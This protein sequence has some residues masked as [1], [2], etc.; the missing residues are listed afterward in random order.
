MMKSVTVGAEV[1]ESIIN[2]S[3]LVVPSMRNVQTALKKAGLGQRLKFLASMHLVDFQ[4]DSPRNVSLDYVLF[5]PNDG[6]IDPNTGLV[7]TNMFDV[8]LDA[9]FFALEALN[10]RS[11]RVTVTETGWPSKRGLKEPATTPDNAATYNGKL[12]RHVISN[13]GTPSRPGQEIDTYI[14]PS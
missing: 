12:V 7:Y 6:S 5:K 3:S 9:R 8:Q 4:I 14:L 2:V 1:T 10:F 11:L 13:T